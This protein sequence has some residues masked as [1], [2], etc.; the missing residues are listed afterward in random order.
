M[1]KKLFLVIVASILLMT[2]CDSVKG[3]NLNQMILN[4]QKVQSSQSY[5]TATLNLSYKAAN[6]KDKQFLKLLNL[7]NNMKFE[8]QTNMQN[9]NT[10]SLGGFVQLKQGKIPFQ[11]Y[12]DKTQMVLLLDNA[13]KAIRIPVQQGDAPNQQMVQS[14]QAKLLPSIVK[15]LPNPNH[16]NVQTNVHYT[17]HGEKITGHKVHAEIYADE[18][19]GLLLKFLDNLAND[20]NGLQQAAT[21]VNELN[22]MT[23]DSTVFTAA[24]LK[25][26]I[27]QFKD[28]F[29]QELPDM[30]KSGAFDRSNFLKTDIL[31]DKNFNERKSFTE[32]TLRKLP[33]DNGGLEGISLKVTSEVWNVNKK[34]TAK[35]VNRT[36]FLSP[37]ASDN[38]FLSTLDKNHS[39]LYRIIKS[40]Q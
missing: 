4:N 23:G 40:F 30:K 13:S 2:A 8:V 32:I 10:V 3:V 12:S 27:Q 31:L 24:Q 33:T 39:V 34:V 25:Q 6:V 37:D 28:Q 7:L 35:K 16:I 19:P 18:V 15:D 1:F 22:K 17:V 5:T 26:F 38:E 20:Q 21:V 36:K 29:N 11:L 9:A 14:I